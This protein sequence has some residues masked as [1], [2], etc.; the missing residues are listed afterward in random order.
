MQRMTAVF[1]LANGVRQYFST[2][3]ANLVPI[4][5]ELSAKQR[6]FPDVS[7]ETQSALQLLRS[8]F[9]TDKFPPGF[10]PIAMKHQLYA[11]VPSR[12]DVEKALVSAFVFF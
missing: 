11:M 2:E 1:G 4:R 3:S 7:N 12:P 9:P 5:V 8:I 10:P 6:R